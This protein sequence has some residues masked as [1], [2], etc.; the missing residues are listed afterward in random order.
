[1]NVIVNSCIRDGTVFYCTSE[2][3]K[4]FAAGDGSDRESDAVEDN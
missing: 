4:N 3:L 2:I 1:M